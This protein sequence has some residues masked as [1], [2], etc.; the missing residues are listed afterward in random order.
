MP[1]PHATPDAMLKCLQ[2]IEKHL[3]KIEKHAGDLNA[4]MGVITDAVL[5]VAD[6]DD[7]EGLKEAIGKLLMLMWELQGN[8][9][10]VMQRLA[11]N[12]SDVGNLIGNVWT[13]I[14]SFQR[15]KGGE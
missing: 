14:E 10:Q 4:Q 11:E 5:G 13:I 1:D 2:Q 7:F 3:G 12:P 15:P 9:A 8:Q 6:H